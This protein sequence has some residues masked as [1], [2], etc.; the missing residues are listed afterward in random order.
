MNEHRHPIARAGAFLLLAALLLPSIHAP[1]AKGQ[2]DNYVRSIESWRSDR[3]L[4]LRS[5]NGWLTVVALEWLSPGEN[6]FG[7]GPGNS[8]RI[9]GEYVPEFAGTIEMSGT[10]GNYSFSVQPSPDAQIML[11]EKQLPSDKPTVIRS[12]RE[13]SPST[14]GLGRIRF[15]IVERGDRAAVRVRD[16]Q[17]PQRTAF[18][19]V[20]N[21]PIDPSWRIRGTF[22]R[23]DE[24]TPLIVPNILGHA[25]T[26]FCYGRIEFE[27]D[28]VKHSLLPMSDAPDDTALFVV[29]GDAT[30]GA[31]TYGAGRFLTAPLQPDGSVD[32]DF[33]KAYNPPC[34]FNEF[35]TCPLPPAGNVL[36]IAIPAGEK[37]Y[38]DAAHPEGKS[39]AP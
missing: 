26:S 6:R 39:S 18:T 14:L 35:T 24:P 31:E 16:P 12:D 4:R 21:Y 11:D 30:N 8:V 22:V 20:E 13:G 5:A 32:L 36:P 7:S 38:V 9:P 29:F 37:A 25:D 19:G 1:E 2:M 23:F 28:G 33:N 15:W 3:D 10:P 34:A 27:R 17:S